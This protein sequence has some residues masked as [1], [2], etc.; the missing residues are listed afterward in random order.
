MDENDYSELE[1]SELLLSV[2]FCYCSLSALPGRIFI[3]RPFQ[4]GGPL[5][6]SAEK[7]KTTVETIQ[8]LVRF[9]TIPCCF[10]KFSLPKCQFLELA[11][12]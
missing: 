1:L 11:H 9:K 6:L 7:K 2:S 4:D 3:L 12:F 8:K 10:S 5:T